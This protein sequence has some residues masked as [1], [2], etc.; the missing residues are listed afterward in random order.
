ME[1]DVLP[2]Y[3]GDWEPLW[4]LVLIL[5]IVV[6]NVCHLQ[7]VGFLQPGDDLK[8]GIL[9]CILDTSLWT[10]PHIVSFDATEI[11][12]NLLSSSELALIASGAFK[13]GKLKVKTMDGEFSLPVKF[14][15][16]AQRYY[17]VHPHTRYVY[18]GRDEYALSSDVLLG[19]DFSSYNDSEADQQFLAS[20]TKRLSAWE[21]EVRKGAFVRPTA[22]KYRLPLPLIRHLAKTGKYRRLSG[23][24][25]AAY[26]KQ[27]QHYLG[28]PLDASGISQKVQDQHYLGLL[29]DASGISQN[30]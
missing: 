24:D 4:L 18:C 3:A 28:L 7:P 8:V 29:L 11:T 14:G 23:E 9:G 5:I 27:Y 15:L 19:I 20:F 10:D 21:C 17:L 2:S 22:R 16:H 12:G 6:V 25:L 1:L 26:H 13:N 30:V